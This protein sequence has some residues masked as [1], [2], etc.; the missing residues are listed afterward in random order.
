MWLD[1]RV[2]WNLSTNPPKVSS[3]GNCMRAWRCEYITKIYSS[4]WRVMGNRVDLDGIVLNT[5]QDISLATVMYFADLFICSSDWFIDWWSVLRPAS[6]T[7]IQITYMTYPGYVFQSSKLLYLLFGLV[8][9]KLIWNQNWNTGIRST[10]TGR[11]MVIV[12]WWSVNWSM[13]LWWEVI[14]RETHDIW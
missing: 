7:R 3:L 13:W 5:S 9:P 12:V 11:G 14:Y 6:I 1:H 4:F 8:G 2:I 10:C